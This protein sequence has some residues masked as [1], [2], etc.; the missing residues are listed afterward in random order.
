MLIIKILKLLQ[1]LAMTIR[2]KGPRA[3][4][5]LIIIYYDLD[6]KKDIDF[7]GVGST[8]AMVHPVLAHGSKFDIT[9]NMIQLI[10]LRGLFEGALGDDPNLYLINLWG[11]ERRKA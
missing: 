7:N 1:F 6:N 5:K 10:N 9:S 3:I 2:T 8:S 4:I 11:F